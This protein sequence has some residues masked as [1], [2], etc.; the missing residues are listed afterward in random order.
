MVNKVRAMETD[1]TYRIIVIIFIVI[2]CILYIYSI[3]YVYDVSIRLGIGSIRATT[4]ICILI[5]LVRISP[6]TGNRL[7]NRSRCYRHGNYW[8]CSYRCRCHRCCGSGSCSRAYHLYC[9][10]YTG[11]L[12]AGIKIISLRRHA[13]WKKG[14]QKKE[15]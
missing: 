4:V 8:C 14:C 1:Q 5:P 12:L 2:Y 6:C 11:I 15:Y 3:M 13:Q 10:S 7:L 9:L